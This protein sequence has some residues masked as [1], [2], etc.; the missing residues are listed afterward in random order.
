MGVERRAPD[1]DRLG[2]A[3]VELGLGQALRVRPEV[4]EAQWIVGADVRRLLDEAAVVRQPVDAGVRRH[5]VV[6][7]AV[8]ADPQCLRELVVA[9]VRPAA[10]AGVGVLLVPGLRYVRVL[11]LDVDPCLRHRD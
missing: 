9:V 10:R 11:D 6:V 2:E 8:R 7:A 5:R 1:H 3:G 4:E